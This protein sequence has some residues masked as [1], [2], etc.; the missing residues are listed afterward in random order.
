MAIKD[1][2]GLDTTTAGAIVRYWSSHFQQR[3]A[4]V[5]NQSP[6]ASSWEFD[7]NV[8][9]RSCSS[10]IKNRQRRTTMS[11]GPAMSRNS[12]RTEVVDSPL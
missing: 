10:Q 1:R 6:T 9:T 2:S 11:V 7:Q 5:A 12:L 3:D 8:D 4:L